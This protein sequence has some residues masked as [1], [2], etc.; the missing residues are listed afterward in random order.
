MKWT[1]VQHRTPDTDR[2]VLVYCGNKEYHVA[3][4]IKLDNAINKN[5]QWFTGDIYVKPNY[6][7]ELPKAPD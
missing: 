3:H 6:W 2:H 1:N 5:C 7:A 4:Y